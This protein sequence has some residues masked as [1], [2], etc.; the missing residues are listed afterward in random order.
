MGHERIGFLPKS[1]SWSH[2]IDQL[3]QLSQFS[4]SDIPVRQIANQTLENIR[5]QYQSMPYNESVIK[6]IQ[7]LATL[8]ISANEKEQIQFLANSGIN[9]KDNISLFSLA[10]NAKNYITTE[11]ESLEV[12]KITQ[13]AVLESIATYE[14]NNRNNQLSL[15]SEES[16]NIWAKI[17]S[18]SAFCELARGF[19]ASF[20]DRYLRYYLER[21]AANSINDYK[22][23]DQFSHNL[24]EEV[25]E[26]SHH[27]FETSKIMQSFAAGWFN[28]HS[29]SG[30]PAKDDIVSFLKLSFEKMREEFRREAEKT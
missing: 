6:A 8:S 29:A 28:N 27:A 22:R 10:V 9:I 16:Q 15:F 12:N 21:A 13:D 18:G 24:T 25:S 19:F 30:I 1:Q 2:I 23:L 17:G 14:N 26:I 7:Y 20:T 4:N 3:S 11:N 5:K